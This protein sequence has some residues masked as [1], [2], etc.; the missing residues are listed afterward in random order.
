MGTISSRSLEQ[1][2]IVQHQ[3]EYAGVW[4]ALEGARLVAQGSS[5]R[6]VLDAARSKGY[7]QPLVV[8]IPSGP[9]LPFGGW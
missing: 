9:E 8:H 5:A 1:D 3:A 4:V 6:V 7:E 2:W